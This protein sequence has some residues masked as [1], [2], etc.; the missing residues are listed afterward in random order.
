M[1]KLEDTDK[2]YEPILK[3]LESEGQEIDP[4]FDDDSKDKKELDQNFGTK[5]HQSPDIDNN[6]QGETVEAEEN[7]DKVEDE[8]IDPNEDTKLHKGEAVDDPNKYPEDSEG[9]IDSEGNTV[10]EEDRVGEAIKEGDDKDIDENFDDESEGTISNNFKD[11][12][13]DVK[14][15]DHKWEQHPDMTGEVLRKMGYEGL[16]IY[17]DYYGNEATSHVHDNIFDKN[18]ED[19]SKAED[20]IDLNYTTT[21]E[22]SDAKGGQLQYDVTTSDAED[23]YYGG[24]SEGSNAIDNKD[25]DANKEDESNGAI[26]KNFEPNKE[27][28]DE[29]EEETE[30]ADDV[31]PYQKD[32]LKRIGTGGEAVGDIEDV[33]KQFKDDKDLVGAT[34]INT[35]RTGLMRK[36]GQESLGC[37]FICNCGQ[38]VHEDAWEAHVL[39]HANEHIVPTDGLEEPDPDGKPSEDIFYNPDPNH[40]IGDHKV[41]ASTGDLSDTRGDASEGYLGDGSEQ[42]QVHTCDICGAGPFKV[43]GA[44][45]EMEK[46]MQAHESPEL[47]DELPTGAALEFKKKAV[48]VPITGHYQD[49]W[50][51]NPEQEDV[52]YYDWTCPQCEKQM[53][54]DDRGSEMEN[55]L[56]FEHGLTDDKL[57]NV[58]DK[59]LED[60]MGYGSTGESKKKRNLV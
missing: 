1:R 41:L 52:T 14:E 32:V 58:V 13:T 46:H 28:T 40:D 25:F 60:Y 31:S 22:L 35:D 20:Q 59:E 51:D 45:D 36:K 42:Y 55:H 4:N 47:G 10:W 17:G 7:P 37:S 8:G 2:F 19:K 39:K 15:D 56:E 23:E 57:D 18:F 9:H 12:S 44:V 16:E 11:E 50:S 26:D 53:K 43:T 49:A 30:E 5:N 3:A 34:D 27:I 54:V 33:N 21:N 6:K 29:V 48:E 24:E 38:E